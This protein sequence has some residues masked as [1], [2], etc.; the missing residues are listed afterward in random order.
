MSDDQY[1]HIYDIYKKTA[2]S[3]GT[4]EY[5]DCISTER[6][7]S[8]NMCPGYYAKQYDCEAPVMLEFGRMQSTPSLPLFPCTLCPGEVA[9]DSVL[10]I[11]QKEQFDIW[12]VYFDN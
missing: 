3:P 10:S 6:K 12:T 9:P 5:I 4:V 2:Q 7:Y 1:Y 11:G 8:Q